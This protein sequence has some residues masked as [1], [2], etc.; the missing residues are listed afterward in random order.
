[1]AR[2]EIRR[3]S[4][5]RMAERTLSCPTAP[6]REGE[7][8]SWVREFAAER[9]H[10]RLREDPDGNLE[11]RRVGVRAS[12]SPLVLAAHM[13][14]PGF[15]AVR[16][17]KRRGGGNRVEALFLGGVPL[18]SFAGSRARFYTPDGTIR[19]RVEKAR[20]DPRSG[21]KRVVLSA[22]RAVPRGA[23]GIWDLPLFRFT[24]RRDLI[25]ACAVD[26]LA[27][28]SGILCLLDAVDRIDRTRR[29]D[30]RAVFTRAEEVGFV[31]ALSIAR[32]RRL[33]KASRIVAIEASMALPD[34]PQ[35]GGPIVRVGDRTSVFD[36]P[37]TRAISAV[38]QKLAGPKGTAFAWQ[39]KLM[40]GGTCES[41]AYQR[42][43]YACTGMCLPLGNYHNV[44][45]E[46]RITPESI[47]LSDLV[48]MVRFFEALVREEARPK[49]ATRPRD[50]LRSRLESL[51]D[52][53]RKNL[54]RSP[55]S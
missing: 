12:R 23:Y 14:H 3:N 22:A 10:L 54:A 13:D 35:G 37:L 18:A 45:R 25:E 41:T 1:M 15:R 30:V 16:S 46:G 47:L 24:R 17:T 34:A 55:F 26:D 40:D 38:G 19:A 29:A 33:P 7:V 27:G 50:P 28:L 8:I 39:R 32:N 48:G 6:Y 9:P 42:F 5:L 4:V 43:G 51:H 20:L 2:S 11:L 52:R 36:D 21:E 53:A 49:K 31:G 44:G